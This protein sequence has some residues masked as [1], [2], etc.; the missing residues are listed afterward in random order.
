MLSA[1]RGFVACVFVLACCPSLLAQNPQ[2]RT[3]NGPRFPTIVFT[4]VFWSTDPSYYSIAIDSAGA[5]TYQSAPSSVQHTGVPYTVRF[6]AVERTRRVIFN[7]AA[8]LNYFADQ[9]QQITGSPAY[10]VV[11]TLDFHYA[12]RNNQLSYSSSSNADVQELN[13]IFEGISETLEFGRRLNY[14]HQHDP[15]ALESELERLQASV[16]TNRMRELQALAASLTSIASD[17]NVEDAVRQRAEAIA[18]QVRARRY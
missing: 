9:I 3:K 15:K 1:R 12:L 5:A 13:S 4:Y 7:L 14:V 2:L 6:Q 17:A 10:M 8:Q 16:E 11:H 18:N